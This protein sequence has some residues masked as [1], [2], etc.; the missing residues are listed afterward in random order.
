MIQK[1]YLIS[2]FNLYEL[3]P[4]FVCANTARGLFNNL[5]VKN[6]VPNIFILRR[7]NSIQ[8]VTVSSGLNFTSLL[9]SYDEICG[10]SSKYW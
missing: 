10:K 5:G 9:S 7:L 8:S 1:I 6:P 4:D 2:F 3:F